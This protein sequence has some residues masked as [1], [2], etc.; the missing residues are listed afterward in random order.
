M[1]QAAKSVIIIL[2]YSVPTFG[3]EEISYKRIFRNMFLQI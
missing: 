3:L 1:K 2:F